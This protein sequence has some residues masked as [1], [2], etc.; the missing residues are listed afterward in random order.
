MAL[1]DE[2]AG[3]MDEQA[4]L[5]GQQVHVTLQLCGFHQK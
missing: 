2:Q 3:L 1:I 5:V 4:K